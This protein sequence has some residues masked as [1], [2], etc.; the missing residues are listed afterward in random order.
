MGNQ[1][2][3]ITEADKG[4]LAGIIDGEG[5]ICMNVRR[6]KWNGWNGIGIDLTVN[7]A[8]TDSGIIHKAKH[9]LNA[10]GVEPHIF[11]KRGSS[12]THENKVEYS[13]AK[14]ILHV[15]ISK[16]AHIKTFLETVIHYL[17]GEKRTRAGLVLEFID[18][19]MNYK[20][21][22]TKSGPSWYTAY[23]WSLV[24]KFYD[25][26][27]SKLLPEVSAFLNDHTCSAA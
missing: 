15:N 26:T 7:I 8:N 22:R 6:K 19:R 14:T 4:W 9:L 18:R 16:M 21:E 23:D 17:A 24:K 11:E 5:S 3:S 20:G 2:E 27:Q 10:L 25:I 1:Q 13:S 12:I